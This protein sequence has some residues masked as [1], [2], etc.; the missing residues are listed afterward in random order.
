MAFGPPTDQPNDDGIYFPLSKGS[1]GTETWHGSFADQEA[2]IASSFI[3]I[4]GASNG[5]VVPTN[6]DAQLAA[7]QT[8]ADATAAA[9]AGKEIWYELN[10]IPLD[11]G[12]FNTDYNIEVSEL[13]V[14]RMINLEV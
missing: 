7:N 10:L 12:P 14:P 1:A 2:A 3:G 13:Q 5:S 11:G 4:I 9:M 6:Q 8:Q